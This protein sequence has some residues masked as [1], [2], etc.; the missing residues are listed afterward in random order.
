M[1]I[2]NFM[3][4][5]LPQPHVNTQTIIGNIS[6]EISRATCVGLVALVWSSVNALEDILNPHAS[7]WIVQKRVSCSNPSP[8]RVMNPTRLSMHSHNC[9][10]MGITCEGCFS[11]DKF[12]AQFDPFRI[13]VCAILL[14][15]TFPSRLFLHYGLLPFICIKE[16]TSLCSKRLCNESH[17]I[18]NTLTFC[19]MRS[20][21]LHPCNLVNWRKSLLGILLEKNDDI[22]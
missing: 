16:F 4:L 17:V 9:D 3:L 12:L 14:L 22:I 11:V 20:W 19:G 8:C 13:S 18:G 21:L 2:P 15:K 10:M 7:P 5:S 6:I 1:T